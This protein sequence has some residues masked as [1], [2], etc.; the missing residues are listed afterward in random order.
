LIDE[1]DHLYQPGWVLYGR[2]IKNQLAATPY[3]DDWFQ[4]GIQR[5]PST[6]ACFF[7]ANIAISRTCLPGQNKFSISWL[8]D[9]FS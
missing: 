8:I 3:I 5:S 6:S 4:E 2:P 7:R 9:L 1:S